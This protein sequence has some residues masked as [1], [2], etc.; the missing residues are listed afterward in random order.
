MLTDE[1]KTMFRQRLLSKPGWV[2]HQIYVANEASTSSTYMPAAP[3]AALAHLLGSIQES[4]TLQYK[5]GVSTRNITPISWHSPPKCLHDKPVPEFVED[6]RE[7]QH[8]HQPEGVMHAEKLLELGQ[9]ALK[10]VEFD[11]HQRQRREPEKHREDHHRQRKEPAHVRDRA[12]SKT[13]RD[14]SP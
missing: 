14:R 12:S 8:D 10:F 6:F 1:M 3:I 2:N 9:F 5:Q 4:E 7:R 13:A 11:H